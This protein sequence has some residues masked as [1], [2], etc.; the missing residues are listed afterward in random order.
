MRG[1]KY[2]YELLYWT[3]LIGYRVHYSLSLLPS[4]G[5]EMSSIYGVKA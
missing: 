3:L 1:I 2:N 4:A 5:R